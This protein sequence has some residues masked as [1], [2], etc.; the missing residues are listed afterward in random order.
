[1]K[2]N[3]QQ[4]SVLLCTLAFAATQGIATPSDAKKWSKVEN[5]SDKIYILTNTDLSAKTTLGTVWCRAKGDKGNGKAVSVKGDSY[6]I[7]PGSHDFYFDTTA[8][9][10]AMHLK[11]QDSRSNQSIYLH[12]TNMDPFV[13]GTELQIAGS[14]LNKSNLIVDPTGYRNLAGGVLFTIVPPSAKADS[15]PDED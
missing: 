4:A 14:P 12:V 10:I 15:S 5:T 1:M 2:L 11:F 8:T 3:V 7:T 13:T 9:R 6:S